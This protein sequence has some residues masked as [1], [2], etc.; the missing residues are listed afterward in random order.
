MAWSYLFSFS[1]HVVRIYMLWWVESAVFSQVWP[2]SL[3]AWFP[4]VESGYRLIHIGMRLLS[5][6]HPRSSRIGT[7]PL[8]LAHVATASMWLP[9]VLATH[10]PS[11]RRSP[12]WTPPH[13]VIA[14]PS[15][16]RRAEAPPSRPRFKVRTPPR[17]SYILHRHFELSV[18]SDSVRRVVARWQAPAMCAIP[19]PTTFWRRRR[20][21]AASPASSRAPILFVVR[22]PPPAAWPSTGAPLPGSP[23]GR[24]HGWIV[25]AGVAPGRAPLPS[26]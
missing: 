5:S 14:A 9:S 20:A 12:R 17:H 7:A 23:R 18:V 16:P 6:H 13:R 8:P 3:H 10:A 25:L 19:G 15:L 1:L 4:R 11:C 21:P 22:P 2:A 26:P 24:A